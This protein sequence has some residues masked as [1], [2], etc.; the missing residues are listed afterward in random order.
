MR[1]GFGTLININ[2]IKIGSIEIAARMYI[3]THVRV[4]ITARLL[5]PAIEG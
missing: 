3:F 2:Q 1:E 5:F 4:C